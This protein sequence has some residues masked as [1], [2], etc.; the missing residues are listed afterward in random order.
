MQQEC[1]FIVHELTIHTRID[2]AV[3]C[4]YQNPLKGGATEARQI[5]K[6]TY[7]HKQKKNTEEEICCYLF[8]LLLRDGK[9]SNIRLFFFLSRRLRNRR[10]IRLEP[11]TVTPAIVATKKGINMG[12]FA[13]EKSQQL[14]CRRQNLNQSGEENLTQWNSGEKFE[15]KI[16]PTCVLAGHL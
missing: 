15:F 3:T 7:D 16:T 14:C 2:T 10:N 1:D 5:K 8:N 6:C 12:I 4:N 9:K 11:E 13:S